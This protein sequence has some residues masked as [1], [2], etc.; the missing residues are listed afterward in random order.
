MAR[1]V[2][3]RHELRADFQTIEVTQVVI[4]SRMLL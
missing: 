1:A 3:A 2:T 4:L